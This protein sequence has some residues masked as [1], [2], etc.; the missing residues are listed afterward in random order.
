MQLS[1]N[2]EL[3]EFVPKEIF[4]N[5]GTRALRFID[6]KLPIIAQGVKEYFNGRLVTIN[7]WAYGGSRNYSGFRPYD[8]LVGAKQSQHKSGRAID[9]IV[10]GIKSEDV[11]KEIIDSQQYFVTL[12]VTAIEENTNGWTHLSCE[13]TDKTDIMVITNKKKGDGK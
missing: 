4:N 13:W 11:Y 6:P 2:F 7:N 9:L 1:K 10:K 5:W 3:R 12:G 8:C